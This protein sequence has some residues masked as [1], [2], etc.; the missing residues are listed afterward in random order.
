MRSKTQTSSVLYTHYI[1]VWWRC[2]CQSMVSVVRCLIWRLLFDLINVFTLMP[3]LVNWQPINFWSVGM[4][5]VY[6]RMKFGKMTLKCRDCRASC[7]PECKEQ[8]PLPC[9]PVGNTPTRGAIA[10]YTPHTN[11]MI[12]AIIVHCINEVEQRGL[13]EVGIYRLSG[14]DKDVKGLKVCSLQCG[15]KE[16]IYLVILLK[17]NVGINA[18]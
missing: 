3:A 18:G 6:F 7:H 1:V 16:D 10:D 17:F 8:V 14:A 2:C 9:V 12:P 5:Y 13:N 4:Y 15:W 11:P